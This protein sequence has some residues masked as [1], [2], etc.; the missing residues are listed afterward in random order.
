MERAGVESGIPTERPTLVHSLG[1]PAH[2][3]EQPY[4]SSGIHISVPPTPVLGLNSGVY[5]SK[6]GAPLAIFSP[7]SGAHLVQIVSS[8]FGIAE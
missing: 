2:R 7:Q 4:D 3:K 1:I 5:R 8:V 6:Q